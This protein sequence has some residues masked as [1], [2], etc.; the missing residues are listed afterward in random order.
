MPAV[1]VA[2]GLGAAP[3][4]LPWSADTAL[5]P[6]GLLLAAG[7]VLI[8]AL[9]IDRRRRVQRRTDQRELHQLQAILR[10]IGDGVITTDTRGHVTF[11]NPEAE[12]LTGWLDPDARGRPHTEVFR[13]LH[14]HTRQPIASPVEGV[15]ASRE[16]VGLAN[17][18]VL[19]SRDGRELAID[20]CAAP[21]L[22]AEQRLLGSV[23][24]F[25][26]VDRKR[27][28]EQQLLAQQTQL[29]R[30]NELLAT[31]A[32]LQGR[33]IAGGP[34]PEVFDEMLATVI[35]IS[36]ST[37]G[38]IAELFH[39]ADGTTYLQ[40]HAISNVVW[41]PPREATRQ[42][43]FTT[44][45]SLFGAVVTTGR[46]VI[47]NEPAT[48]PRR[49]GLPPGHPPLHCFLGL[50][51]HAGG[52]VAGVI[53]VAN[54]AGGYSLDLVEFLAPVVATCNTLT[55]ALRS[56]RQ[57]QAA[58]QAL[59]ASQERLTLALQAGQMGIYDWDL[60]T[61][62]LIWSAE[63]ERLFGLAA[64]TFAQTYE[65]FAAFVHPDDLPRIRASAQYARDTRT[66]CHT[67]Y[68]IRRADGASRWM[69]AR[70]RFL[71]DDRGEPYRMI[72]VAQDVSDRKQAEAER[73]RLAMIARRTANGVIVTDAAGR[74]EWVNDG[75]TRLS[76]YTL[77]DVRGRRP[78]DFLHGPGTDQATV[79]RLARSEGVHQ[80]LLQY[81]RD[82]RP[83]WIDLEVQAVH[84]EHGRLV[85]YLSLELDIT[86][87]KLAETA[88]RESE[89]R[90]RMIVDNMQDTVSL[91]DTTGRM[92]F[93]TPSAIRLTGF[94]VA[95]TIAADL[96]TIVH[97]DD[98]PG[99]YAGLA[100]VLRGD[101]TQTVWRHR[102]HDGGYVWLETLA[103]PVRDAAG[104][105]VRIVCNSRDI[106]DRK[107]KET[108]EEQLRQAQKMEAVGQLAGGIAHDFNNLLTVITGA[109]RLALDALAADHP[110]H[111]LIDQLMD[112]SY[113]AAD[114]IRGLLAFSRK[115]V[116]APRILDVG[117]LVRRVE[118]MLV[119]VLG[120][121][122]SLE[123]R[124]P[125]DDGW[126][127]FADPV[128]LEQ[129][130]INLAVNAR[131]AMPAGGRLRVEVEGAELDAAAAAAFPEAAA[132]AYVLLTVAD[133][134]CGMTEETRTR[135]FEPFFTTKGP[136]RGTGLGLATVYGIVRQSNGF[137]TVDSLV[138]RGSTFRLYFPR[139]HEP[140][141]PAPAPAASPPPPV[142][143][144]HTILLV[145]DEATLRRLA[146]RILEREGFRV[147]EASSGEEALTCR[148]AH[149]GPID[150]LV[151][152]VVM[153]G[154]SGADL[155]R[156]LAQTGAALPVLYISGYP[157]DLLGEKGVLRPDTA[158]LQKP[159]RL[160][161]LVERVRRA[162]QTDGG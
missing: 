72:G 117:D 158:F 108:L 154:M 52:E 135:L 87:R 91:H 69:A 75:F 80:G 19:L 50:P 115:Q 46:P 30:Q 106:S 6:V 27:R 145:E 33:F 120:E 85:S 142:V 121:G 160:E 62:R 3:A 147:L 99:V 31:L 38:F 113:R 156:R 128:Q 61:G 56:Q 20:D 101:P 107:K 148:A 29:Q 21:V 143:R 88:L 43:R 40:T 18:T 137:L 157:A 23:L 81:H 53:G 73:D 161:A 129:V 98:L 66:E 159:F 9:L 47:A 97:P 103:T 138:G 7:L 95:E 104:T 44:L 94:S 4:L 134:G 153:A 5:Y 77:D 83:Y 51:I 67:E 130:L 11:L 126:H 112:A 64:G 26:D 82:G 57:R 54:R 45:R 152:D 13:I 155:A 141:A 25:R 17:H 79:A 16:V 150:L 139:S 55:V 14:E 111:E 2:G 110:A 146:R 144:G 49:C 118:R 84:D 70:G 92:L 10:S 15:L 65:A 109:G 24:V 162:L 123:V 36:G 1:L 58:E 132:G 76:G 105:V 100:V 131:D 32:Q 28:Y 22:D 35:R 41:S 48:D 149:P 136:D 114:L 34:V 122:I 151:T 63:H 125:A 78:A 93:V 12:Q 71:L 133:T 102:C 90:Y 89:A 42:M 37:Y 127:V 60:S 96:P 124:T 8:V 59:A 86:A 39:D 140:S 68:R 116:L 74:I 119:R